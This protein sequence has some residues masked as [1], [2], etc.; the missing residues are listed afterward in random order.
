MLDGTITI[1]FAGSVFSGNRIDIDNQAGYPID[2][3]Q[4]IFR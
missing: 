2:T 4:A 1:D 3:T